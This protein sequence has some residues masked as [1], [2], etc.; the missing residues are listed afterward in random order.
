[1]IEN[2]RKLMLKE[3][4]YELTDYKVCHEDIKKSKIIIPSLILFA[5]VAALYFT[6]ELFG[7]PVLGFAFFIFVLIPLALRKGEVYDVFIITPELLIKQTTKNEVVAIAYDEIKKFGTDKT[8][9]I[10]RDSKKSI[11]LDPAILSEDILVIIDILEAKGKTFDKTK[12]YMIRPIEISI[13]NNEV[14]INDLEIEETSTE[15]LVSESYKDYEMLTPGFIRDII[16]M[17]SVIEDSYKKDNNLF[18]NIYSFEVNPGHPENTMFESQIAYDCIMIFED[19]EIS[20][21]TKKNSNGQEEEIIEPTL[22]NLAHAIIKGV[23]SDWK[24][25]EKSIELQFSVGLDIVRTS[26][27]YKEVIV[28]WNAFNQPEKSIEDEP[29]V[30]VVT[31]VEDDEPDVEVVIQVEEV[32][33]IETAKV[34]D[35]IM[36]EEITQVEEVE[37]SEPLVEPAIEESVVEDLVVEE[38]VIE[39]KEITGS[40]GTP[41]EGMIVFQL[42]VLAKE[43]GIKGY[44][45]LRKQELIDALRNL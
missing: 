15:K 37:T 20:K 7:F 39:K 1:M 32:E 41:L 27:E 11:S 3:Y 30:E 34:E 18:F 8:G 28:G 6:M 44:N 24:Y 31:K 43:H 17:N 38:P 14:K 10:I 25:S 12:D 4:K 5:I 29:D 16:L 13:I 33:P 36:P 2:L 23:I 9:V 22:D 26:F 45:K 40:D 19:V 42:K 21:I 35:E